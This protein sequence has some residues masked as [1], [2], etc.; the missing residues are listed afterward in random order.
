M[1]GEEELSELRAE[2]VQA[3]HALARAVRDM[4]TVEEALER[5]LKKFERD[6]EE[7]ERRIR[8]RMRRVQ[9]GFDQDRTP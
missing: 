8:D 5:E 9:P 3:D 1:D 4:E 7:R 2:A 6:E